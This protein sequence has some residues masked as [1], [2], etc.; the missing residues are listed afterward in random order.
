MSSRPVDHDGA[1][2]M[3][4]RGKGPEFMARIRDR[5]LS[6]RVA[7]LVH[8]TEVIHHTTT[9]PQGTAREAYESRVKRLREAKT[10]HT[11][12]PKT[13]TV[14]YEGAGSEYSTTTTLRYTD[15]EDTS[16]PTP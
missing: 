1:A 6:K 10:P 15:P 8:H 7:H 16:C 3:G 4:G 9:A 11:A 2:T 13:L 5:P 14:T 12:D